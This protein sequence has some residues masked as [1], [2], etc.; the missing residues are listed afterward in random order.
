MEEEG[1]WK[2]RKDVKPVYVELTVPLDRRPCEIGER[3]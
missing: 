2:D 1:V 3:G